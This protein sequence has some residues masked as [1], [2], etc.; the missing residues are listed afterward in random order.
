MLRKLQALSPAFLNRIDHYLLIHYPAIWATKIH[1]IAFVSVLGLAALSLK[2][3]FTPLS[4]QDLPD[5][6]LHL[7][8]LM[9]PTAVVLVL[10]G[11]RVY[12]FKPDKSFGHRKVGEAWKEQLIYAL[13]ILMLL[14]GP[15]AYNQ[16]LNQKIDQKINDQVFAQDVFVLDMGSEYYFNDTRY[17]QFGQYFL[18]K[19]EAFSL[20]S[21]PLSIPAETHEHLSQIQLL[22]D[23]YN[24]YSKESFPTSA[25][26]AFENFKNGYGYHQI[27]YTKTREQASENAMII[28]RIKTGRTFLTGNSSLNMLLMMF[29]FVC[30]AFGIFQQASWKQ[31][32][33]ALGAAAAGGL[34]IG[35]ASQFLDQVVQYSNEEDWAMLIGAG[36]YGVLLTQIFGNKNTRLLAAWKG[37]AILIVSLG[38]PVLIMC[39]LGWSNIMPNASNSSFTTMLL[40]IAG[41]SYLLWNGLYRRRLDKIQASPTKN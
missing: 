23:T 16:I 5:P 22:I 25:I 11:I 37:I 39:F 10:W 2:A 17:P 28:T 14:G 20:S 31:F 29:L 6:D 1:Q 3:F 40:I 38:F 7:A 30:L 12:Q 35:L 32:L 4:L 36:M 19:E 9:I 13:G 41:V 8:L 27:S 34:I 33:M 15:F 18:N 24:R 21:Q 26:S